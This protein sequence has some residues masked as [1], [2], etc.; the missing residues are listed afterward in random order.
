M[1]KQTI[2]KKHYINNINDIVDES[3]QFVQEIALSKN[4]QS[5]KVMLV[6]SDEIGNIHSATLYEQ[7]AYVIVIPHGKKRKAL[8]YGNWDE[9]LRASQQILLATIDIQKSPKVI[10]NQSKN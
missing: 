4:M 6:A 7:E 2:T 3:K 5:V 8:M 9:A 10:I 1:K